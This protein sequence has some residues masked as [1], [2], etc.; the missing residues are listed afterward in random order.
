MSVNAMES[1]GIKIARGDGS[2]PEAFTNIPEIREFTGPGGSASVIDVSDLDST[3]REKRLGLPDEGQLSFT[4]HYIADNAVHIN[5]RSDRANRTQRNFTM[6]WTDDS[7]KRVWSF[8]GFVTE[9][10]VSGGV[11]DVVLANV[12]I[13]IT[14]AITEA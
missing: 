4:I 7:P 14:G 6:T 12:V 9:F 13:E 10:S 11:D 3:F 5:L 2:S 8:S 1:Q